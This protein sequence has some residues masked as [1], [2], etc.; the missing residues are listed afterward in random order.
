MHEA[1]RATDGMTLEEKRLLAERLLRQRIAAAERT[2]PLSYAQRGLWLAHQIAPE[3]PAYNVGFA[4]RVLSAPDAPALRRAVAALV[5]RHASLRI[6]CGAGSGGP[7]QTVHAEIETPFEE[8]H[9]PQADGREIERRV[10][11]AHRRPFDLRRGPVVRV[12]LFIGAEETVLLLSAHHVAV[13]F[14]SLLVLLDEL[15]L[16]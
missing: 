15:R 5:A 8:I 11:R 16:L 12:A 2:F 4:A 6:T 3:S 1:S 13:D 9:L 10:Q 7:A 14:W